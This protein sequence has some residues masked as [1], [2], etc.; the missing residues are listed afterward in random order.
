MTRAQTK[1]AKDLLDELHEL[2]GGQIGDVQLHAA[3]NERSGGKYIPLTEINEV[4]ELCDRNGW[5]ITVR[6]KFK[7]SLR[8]LSDEGQAVRLQMK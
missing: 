1:L 2:D 6:S 4:L 7:G 5:I 3:L 8:S